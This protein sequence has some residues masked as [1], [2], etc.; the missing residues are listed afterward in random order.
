[1]G[2]DRYVSVVSS[3]HTILYKLQQKEK[4]KGD[5]FDINVI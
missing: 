5:K 2:A 4:L 1:M 3:A